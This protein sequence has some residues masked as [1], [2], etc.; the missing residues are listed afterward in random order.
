MIQVIPFFADKEPVFLPLLARG[1]SDLS[2]LRFNAIGIETQVNTDL[3]IKH[4]DQLLE[5]PVVD[6][7][8]AGE[9]LWFSGRLNGENSDF[10]V[11]LILYD[12]THKQIVFRQKIQVPEEKFLGEWEK[13]LQNFIHY[14]NDK[15]DPSVDRRM[16]T[17]SM[18]AFLAFRKGLETLAQVK[19]DR[20]RDEGLESLLEAVA[21]DPEFI[22]A[23]DILLLFLIQNDVTRNFDSSVSILERLREV[24]CDHPRIPLVLAEV[25]YQWGNNEKA[26]QFLKEIVATFPD[27]VEGWIRLALFY[28]SLNRLE[29]ALQTLDKILTIDPTDS[30]ALDLI[31]AIYASQGK[32]ERAEKIWLKALEIEPTRV[33][34][35]NNLALLKEENEDSEKA[36]SFYKQA[37]SLSD[38]W[39]GSF[40]HYGTFCQRH[41][42]LEEAVVLLTKAVQLNPTHVQSF[43]NLG[44]VQIQLSRYGEAQETLLQ[45][46]Q[47]APDNTTRRQTLQVLNQLNAPQIKTELR[48]RQLERIWESGRHGSVIIRLIKSFFQAK[49]HWFYWYLVGHI[50]FHF[51]LKGLAFVFWRVGLNFDPGFPLLKKV[52]LDYWNNGYY[53]KA[54]PVL[55][56]AHKLH[57]TDQ[58]IARAYLQTLVNLGE[59]EELQANINNLSQ[60]NPINPS[61]SV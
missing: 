28:H 10:V 49:N 37:I 26:E 19:N 54:L 48:L 12:P 33:N 14:L 38:T 11:M 16:Y 39:W 7:T 52:G 60:L 5:L 1:L 34:I 4:W 51:R 15:A 57:Q 58:E 3:E 53:R 27:F 31:G 17:H 55:R 29:E 59:L 13:S 61:T 46:L 43:Q 24:A 44:A 36:E 35:L 18:A 45:L 21:Y 2:A 50:G 9:E 32:R 56:R 20:M 41:A 42:R 8:W 23:A 6:F 25:Y 30:T 22:E 40:F 47:L